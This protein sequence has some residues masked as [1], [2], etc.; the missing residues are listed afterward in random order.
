MSGPSLRDV[1]DVRDLPGLADLLAEDPRL[2]STEMSPMRHHP[3]GAAP[4]NYLAMLR[5]DNELGIWKDVVGTGPIAELLI[6]NGAPV[7]GSPGDTETPLM[8]QPATATRRSPGSWSRPPTISA[9]T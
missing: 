3:L 1:L 9:P 7:D 4:L 2:A 6:A 8:T 5:C